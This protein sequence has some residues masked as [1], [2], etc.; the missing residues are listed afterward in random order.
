MLTPPWWSR[1][2]WRISFSLTFFTPSA[3]LLLWKLFF[4]PVTRRPTICLMR[5]GSIDFSL[6][7]NANRGKSLVEDQSIVI[8]DFGA[9]YSQ[10]IAR[11]IRQL[12]VFTAVL[13][14][15]AS[16]AEIQS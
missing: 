14:C 9:Q 13:P 5:P 11:R 3:R 12:K 16:L 1:S 7:G 15:T 10:L 4:N 2:R 6:H 8:L